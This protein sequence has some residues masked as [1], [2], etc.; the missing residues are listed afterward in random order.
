MLGG[1]WRRGCLEDLLDCFYCDRRPL[2]NRKLV[3]VDEVQNIP[4]FR[5][6]SSMEVVQAVAL[7]SQDWDL[8]ETWLWADQRWLD[9]HSSED[10]MGLLSFLAQWP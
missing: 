4:G 5:Q 2:P 7:G 3:L 8:A 9:R 6:G 10:P 1:R